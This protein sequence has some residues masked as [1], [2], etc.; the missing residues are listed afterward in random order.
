MPRVLNFLYKVLVGV[1]L[2]VGLPLVGWGIGNA[3]GFFAN[4][5]RIAYVIFTI[6]G[7]LVMNAVFPNVSG[8]Y[9]AG[10][11]TV[12][13][14]KIALLLFQILSIAIVIVGPYCD[15]R[16]ILVM[17]DSLILRVIGIALYGIGFAL[18]TWAASTL[19]KL[20]SYEVTIQKEHKLV[21]SGPFRFVRHPRYL[22]IIIF[23]IGLS[24][25]FRSWGA[26]ILT[27]LFVFALIWRIIDEE[28]LMAETFGEE[29]KG[30][31]KRTGKVVPRLRLG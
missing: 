8:K 12:G 5:G 30:H 18:M 1:V 10:E 20:F 21:I 14:Q 19:G 27:L 31:C 3:A 2:F 22:G 29:W 9:N 16:G 23:E 11:K 17:Q 26:M 13:R 15:R 25:A 6:I 4:P 7:Q 24:L 28:K